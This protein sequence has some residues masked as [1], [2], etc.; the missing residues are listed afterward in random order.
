MSSSRNSRDLNMAGHRNGAGTRVSAGER[1]CICDLDEV[2]TGSFGIRLLVSSHCGDVGQVAVVGGWR[3][4]RQRK[5]TK[6][7]ATI[8]VEIASEI[9]DDGY[10]RWETRRACVRICDRFWLSPDRDD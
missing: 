6:S 10:V 5:V 7:N 8:F 2:P 4:C 1:M 3:G 9:P